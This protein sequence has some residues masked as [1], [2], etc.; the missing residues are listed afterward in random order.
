MMPGGMFGGGFGDFG[1]L[2]ML[3]F[4]VLIIGGV[5]LLVKWLV[6]QGRQG[7]APASGRES[8]LDVLRNRYARGEIDREEFQAKKRDLL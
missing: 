6:D 3:V 7:G 4:W 5:V 8:A 1:M 2:L